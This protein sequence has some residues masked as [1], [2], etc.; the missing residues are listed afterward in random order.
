MKKAAIWH[1]CEEEAP[2]VLVHPKD[3]C[4]PKIVLLGGQQTKTVR[5]VSGGHHRMM[6]YQ[7]SVDV[8]V[9]KLKNE[10]VMSD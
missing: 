7:V 9:S 1:R 10:R 6:H 5:E 8:C 4:L 2:A 3:V